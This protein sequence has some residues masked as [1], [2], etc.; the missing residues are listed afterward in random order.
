VTT[1][2][3]DYDKIKPNSKVRLVHKPMGFNTDVEVVGLKKFHP[4]LNKKAEVTFTN[5]RTDILNYQRRLNRA[6]NQMNMGG[7]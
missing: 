7:N 2:Y 6:I 1:N 4:A 5:N 3:L